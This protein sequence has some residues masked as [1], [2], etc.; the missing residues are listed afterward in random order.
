MTLKL[1]WHDRYL[2]INGNQ[3]GPIKSSI[4]NNEAAKLAELAKRKTALEIGSAYGYSTLIIAQ[5]ARH[6]TTIDPH[7][8]RE[9]SRQAL[10][11]NLQAAELEGRVTILTQPSQAILPNLTTRFDLAFIDGDHTEPAITQDLRNAWALLKPGGGLAAHDYDEAQCPD[12]KPA[13]DRFA[14]KTKPATTQ[15]VDTLWI[16]TKPRQQNG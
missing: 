12:V 13:I 16:A 1:D 6:L 4:T 14:A 10:E 7:T 3:V 11:A 5:A 15:L 8:E 2:T 9:G